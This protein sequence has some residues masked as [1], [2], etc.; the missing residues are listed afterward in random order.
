[1]DSAIKA[2]MVNGR[3]SARCAEAAAHVLKGHGLTMSAFI[4]NCIEYVAKQ[5][6]VPECGFSV[7]REGV[8]QSELR[9]FI[10][11]LEARPMPGKQDYEGFGEDELIERLRME[12]YGY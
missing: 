11:E 8:D 7:Q 2:K 12:R 4:R 6:T 9:A 3:V 1:M 5:G 10:E